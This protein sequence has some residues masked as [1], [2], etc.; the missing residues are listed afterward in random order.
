MP[1]EVARDELAVAAPDREQGVVDLDG[2]QPAALAE[3]VRRPPQ[4]R[5]VVH[6]VA[7]IHVGPRGEQRFLHGVMAV[8]R[9]HVERGGARLVARANEIGLRGE[10]GAH[11]FDVASL[12]SREQLGGAARVGHRGGARPISSRSSGLTVM[13]P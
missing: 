1:R 3:E 12:G 2:E 10:Q 4:R 8:E 9:R 6:A 13:A 11:G 5:G 7:R